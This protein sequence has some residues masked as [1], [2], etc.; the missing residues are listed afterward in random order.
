[1]QL[2]LTGEYAI[3]AMIYM[4][5]KPDG[6]AFTIL[7]ISSEN[8]IPDQFLRKIIALLSSSGIINS[9]RGR[10]GGVKLNR[11]AKEITPL[12][13]IETVEGEMA[14]NKCLIDKEFCSNDRWCS[15]HTLWCDAQKNLKKILSSKTIYQLAR[16]NEE[17]KQKL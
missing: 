16:E 11:P 6:T 1:M 2:T 17:R 13:I 10:G 15:V 7:E 8:N 14:L 3:R 5:S 4:A 9:Q 12:E